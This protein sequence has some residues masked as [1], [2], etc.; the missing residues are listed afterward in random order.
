MVKA[1]NKRLSLLVLIVAV[2]LSISSVLTV[3]P[4]GATTIS[5]IEQEKRVLFAAEDGYYTTS[6]AALK[7]IGPNYKGGEDTPALANSVTLTDFSSTDSASSTNGLAFR[8]HSGYIAFV[9]GAITFKDSVELTY[10]SSVTFR[11]WVRLSNDEEFCENLGHGGN[12]GVRFYGLNDTGEDFSGHNL[13]KTIKQNEWIDYTVS[14]TELEKLATADDGAYKLTGLQVGVALEKQTDDGYFYTG[15]VN[16]GNSYIVIDYITYELNEAKYHKDEVTKGGETVLASS[17]NSQNLVTANLT[18]VNT[19]GSDFRNGKVENVAESGSSNS[20]VWKFC[21]R[22]GRPCA[23]SQAI[24]FTS[25]VSIAEVESLTIRMKAHFS[26]TEGAYL[27]DLGGVMVVGLNETDC[28]KGDYSHTIDSSV[29][30]DQWI[31]YTIS[32]AELEKLATESIILGIQIAADTRGAKSDADFY[33]GDNMGYASALFIDYVYYT[34]KYTAEFSDENGSIDAMKRFT[35]DEK[36]VLPDYSLS[37]KLFIGWKLSVEGVDYLYKAGEEVSLAENVVFNAVTIDFTMKTGASIRVG[38]DADES[39]L[40]FAVRYNAEQYE[41]IKDFV[42]S[43]GV[44]I[45]PTESLSEKTFVIDN[46]KPNDSSASMTD[47][48]LL[49]QGTKTFVDGE[50]M[51]YTAVMTKIH[52][53]NLAKNFSARGYIEVNYTNGAAYVYTDYNEAYHSRSVK[54]VAQAVRNDTEVYERFT[55]A[56]QKVIDTYAGIE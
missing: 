16:N 5:E 46:F 29:V 54:Y 10:V 15:T 33:I 53:T 44:I 20:N 35:T 34:P 30:Q 49:V 27:T 14:G 43:K 31:D 51:V 8:F 23:P 9:A 28:R 18:D 56:Q 1:Q 7:K 19:S 17:D 55:E 25:S 45:V 48:M 50:D 38:N 12:Y 39:G 3:F 21:F 4:V 40:R 47:R 41:Q 26:S 37:D 22:S 11:I 36:V 6:N 52:S 2:V 24:Q 42:I 13:E 32:G